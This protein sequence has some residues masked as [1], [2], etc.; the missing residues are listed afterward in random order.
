MDY[1][2]IQPGLVQTGLAVVLLL[3][4]G[5]IYGG[6]AIFCLFPVQ[7]KQMYVPFEPKMADNT[8][9]RAYVDF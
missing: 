8:R 3:A 7:T 4:A 9:I 2:P 5:E 6:V 1:T